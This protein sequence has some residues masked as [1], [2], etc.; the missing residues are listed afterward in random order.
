M[1]ITVEKHFFSLAECV[2][3]L[4]E[5]YRGQVTVEAKD[6][7][8]EVI[9][10]MEMPAYLFRGE[11]TQYT[12]TTATIQRVPSDSALTERGRELVAKLASLIECDL[13]EFLG[14]SQI[15]SA[16]FAQHYG[17]PTELL[18]LTSDTQVAGYFAS[19]GKLGGKGYVAVFPTCK[20]AKS[21]MLIDLRNHSSADRPRRQSAF[22]LFHKT[23]LDL[24]ATECVAQL[25]SVWFSFDLVDSDRSAFQHLS[26]I[27]DAHTDP[28]AGALQLVI[29]SI[30]KK[31]GKLPD[32]IARWLSKRIAAAPFV[33][34]IQTTN[35]ESRPDVVQLV[36][37]ESATL[38]FDVAAERERSYRYWSSKYSFQVRSDA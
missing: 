31:H 11:S 6:H 36:S 13:R 15:D 9:G 10:T 8:N 16:G 19:T 3:A 4:G 1:S 27:L 32:E 33:A 20:L 24:K 22:A 26:S 14:L 38:P 17:L 23:H 2:S 12:S 29:D 35:S 18:D 30:V 7:G 28:V 25:E 5:T 37:A 21:S 34:E